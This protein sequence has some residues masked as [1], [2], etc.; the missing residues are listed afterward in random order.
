MLHYNGIY[1]F[2]T[3]MGNFNWG[4]ISRNNIVSNQSVAV[5]NQSV[6]TRVV[7][8]YEINEKTLW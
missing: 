1:P 4:P 2:I 6:V 8:S 5:S 7:I 3:L